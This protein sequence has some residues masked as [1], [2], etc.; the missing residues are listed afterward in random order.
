[1]SRIGRMPITVPAGVEVK[2]GDNNVVTVKGPK[3]TLTKELSAR[4]TIKQDGAQLVVERPSDEKQDRAL[5]GLTRSLLFNM[6][7]GVTNG[8]KKELEVNGVGYRVQKQG[9]DLVMNLGYSHQVIMSEIDGITIEAPTPNKIIISGADKQKVGQFAAEVREK[10]PPEPYKGKGIKYA[11][12]HI[13]R[14]EGKTG[15][16]GK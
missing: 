12:E 10:R 9:T 14:K 2:I 8:Y 1:M 7:E 4:M 5:H 11:D 15:K 16:G 3:G 13:R 6:V